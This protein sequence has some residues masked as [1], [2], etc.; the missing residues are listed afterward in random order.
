[1]IQA[2]ETVPTALMTAGTTVA[3]IVP[4]IRL[5]RPG[6]RQGSGK[7]PE[8][9]P[10]D[11]CDQP[12]AG[13]DHVQGDL[14]EGPLTKCTG[15][16]V[17][18]GGPSPFVGLA[19]RPICWRTTRGRLTLCTYARGEY[20]YDF[21]PQPTAPEREIVIRRGQRRG[22]DSWAR[23]N[24]DLQVSIRLTL[25]TDHRISLATCSCVSPLARRAFLSSVR[26]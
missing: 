24:R 25:D 20:T 5:L 22:A 7:L 9:R 23:R 26:R 1:V 19:L 10:T 18:A 6:L 3:T 21:A 2:A 4:V 14:L 8:P 11:E 15:L 13:Y 17:G 16:P 12:A